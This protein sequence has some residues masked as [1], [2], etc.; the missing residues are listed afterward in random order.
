M[1]CS[2]CCRNFVIK[3]TDQ[4]K[5]FGTCLSDALIY[6]T[7]DAGFDIFDLQSDVFDGNLT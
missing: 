6:Q 1:L 2:V 7:N 4:E 5:K 3:K